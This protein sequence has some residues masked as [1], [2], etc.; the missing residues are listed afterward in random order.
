MATGRNPNS[1]PPPGP[2]P[3]PPPPS[4]KA[5]TAQAAAR[6]SRPPARWGGRGSPPPGRCLDLPPG[7]RAGGAPLGIDATGGAPLGIDVTDGGGQHDDDDSRAGGGGE[8]GSDS[9]WRSGAAGSRREAALRQRMRRIFLPPMVVLLHPWMAASGL[10]VGSLGSGGPMVLGP[11]LQGARRRL[12]APASWNRGGAGD[13]PGVDSGL[14]LHRPVR[15]MV[16]V[17]RWQRT[18][19]VGSEFWLSSHWWCSQGWLKSVVFR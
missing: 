2:P 1:P 4:P 15:P 14:D 18:L 6:P 10:L 9:I 5:R 8:R 13:R 16:E 19:F 11:W 12:A 7:C 17:E 3:P